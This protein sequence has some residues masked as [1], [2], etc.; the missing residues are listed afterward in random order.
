MMGAY[1]NTTTPAQQHPMGV[2][3]RVQVMTG[4]QQANASHAPGGQGPYQS[5]LEGEMNND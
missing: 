2:D 4:L 3:E 1:M 5:N